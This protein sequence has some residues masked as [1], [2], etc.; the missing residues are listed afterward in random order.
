VRHLQLLGPLLVTLEA[1]RNPAGL[2]EYRFG[3]EVRRG[4]RHDQAGKTKKTKRECLRK[5]KTE[6]PKVEFPPFGFFGFDFP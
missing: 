5:F 1:L 2:A 6:N 3:G 4:R